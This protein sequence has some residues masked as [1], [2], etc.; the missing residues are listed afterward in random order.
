M[1]EHVFGPSTVRDLVT[2]AALEL[3]Y[4]ADD[5]ALFAHALGHVDSEG[6]ALP[7]FPWDP[8][9]RLS[10]RCKLDAIYFILYGIADPARPDRGIPDVEYIFSTFPIVQRNDIATY[11]RYRTRDLTIAWINALLAGNPDANVIG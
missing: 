9:R 4:T 7:A 5:L 6:H 1:Y 3:A 2:G 10:L 8:E 11:G